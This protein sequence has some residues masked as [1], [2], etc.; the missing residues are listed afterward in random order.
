MKI[1]ELTL[2]D[3]CTVPLVVISATARKT[4]SQ[5]DY[6]QLTLSDGT[7]T[8]SGNYWDWKGK[9]IPDK[10][11]ILN[12]FAQITEWAGAKQL[13]ISS[14]SK[15]EDL[16]A[17]DFMPSSGLDLS[18]IY[19]DF[20][21]I[22]SNIPD[23]FYR[24]L[25]QGILEDLS[26]QW[27]TAPGAMSMH[28][29]YA[30]GT[31]IHSLSVTRLA[32]AMA[33]DIPE[34]NI[35]LATAGAMLHDLG[36]LFGYEID[37]LVCTMTD[38]GKLYEHL[39]IGAEFVGNHAINLGL[40]K[41]DRADAKIELLRHIIL[42]HHGTP[43]HGAV[44]NPVL[45]EAYVVHHADKLDA[46]VEMLNEASKK[47]SK[48]KWTEKIYPLNNKPHITPEYVNAVLSE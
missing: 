46:T 17:T 29:A 10:G 8:I 16:P 25:C 15:N 44:I 38:E 45:L 36:K 6:L 22:A 20:Y 5:K 19:K 47:V 34:C 13:N 30:G 35:S 11:T 26:S 3:I 31:M 39:F 1:S 12:V 14:I 33:R 24:P 7:D 40:M 42:S 21:E 23:D 4:K 43:E 41:T 48:A 2:N 32:M 18:T 9:V 28:H 37:G 27:L